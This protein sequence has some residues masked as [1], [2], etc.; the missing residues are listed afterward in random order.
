MRQT[1]FNQ[2]MQGRLAFAAVLAVVGIIGYLIYKGDLSDKIKDIVLIFVTLFV[3]EV[4][5]VYA[6]FFDGTAE[7]A[8]KK[9][10][11]EPAEPP[12]L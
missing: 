6:Y 11:N 5:S 12:L 4:K 3:A 7:Q 8:A 1:R 2:K 9:Q 10:G